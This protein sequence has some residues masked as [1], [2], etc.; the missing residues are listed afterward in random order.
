MEKLTKKPVS[1]GSCGTGHLFKKYY[2]DG[3]IAITAGKS[4]EIGVLSVNLP[5]AREHQKLN[6]NEFFVK[7]YGTGKTMNKP[8]FD[9]GLFEKIG[10]PFSIDY[11]THFSKFEKWRVKDEK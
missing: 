2:I 4:G 7:L 9:T 6:K 3:N 11:E 1:F 8:C 10:E 5:E